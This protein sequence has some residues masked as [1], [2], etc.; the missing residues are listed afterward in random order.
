MFLF[1]QEGDYLCG[2]TTSELLA[3]RDQLANASDYGVPGTKRLGLAGARLMVVNGLTYWDE[4][5]VLAAMLYMLNNSARR[6][7]VELALVP[8]PVRFTGLTDVQRAYTSTVPR[9]DLLRGGAGGVGVAA[10][11]KSVLAV[12]AGM[13]ALDGEMTETKEQQEQYKAV[14]ALQGDHA[15]SY[16]IDPNLLAPFAAVR[17]GQVVAT[18]SNGSPLKAPFD[19]HLALGPTQPNVGTGRTDPLFYLS[20]KEESRTRTVTLPTWANLS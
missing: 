6:G 8:A 7:N 19:C 14:G 9:H 11:V 3:A 15:L 5:N 12:L 2:I 1:P 16:Q 20:F 4:Y 17:R 10:A 13:G 18:D